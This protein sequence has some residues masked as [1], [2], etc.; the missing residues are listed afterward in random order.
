M[1]FRLHVQ[2]RF[3]AAIVLVAMS[4]SASPARAQQKPEPVFDVHMHVPFTQKNLEAGLAMMDTLNVTR[5]VYIGS[6][7][8]LATLPSG[9]TQ[10]LL[11]ALIF[12]CEGGRMANAGVVCFPDSAELPDI[13]WLRKEVVAG[14]I[15]VFGEIS[16]QY[17]GMSPDDKRLEP[18]YALAEELDVPVGIHLGIGPPGAAYQRPGFPARKSPNY[19]G[20]AGDPMLLEKVLVRHPKLRLYVMHAAWPEIDHMIYML[21]MHPQLYVDISVL[22]FAIPRP[23]YNEALKRLVDA[24][25]ADRIMFGSDGGPQLLRR[26][27]VAIQEADFLTPQQRR[28]ILYDNAARF[29]KLK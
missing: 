13:A 22:Q 11:P 1:T 29:F 14:R 6:S 9:H 20:P 26:G 3:K 10:E 2:T 15:K 12:P 28:G 16:A 17:M 21:Y 19:S 5:A 18:Y 8:Q 7:E 25:F 24:G 23:A 27:I 4:V